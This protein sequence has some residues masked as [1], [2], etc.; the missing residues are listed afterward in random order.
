MV[1]VIKVRYVY[2]TTIKT[3]FGYIPTVCQACAKASGVG[4]GMA[5]WE[6]QPL[7]QRG[8][9]GQQLLS[10]A[11]AGQV[12]EEPSTGLGGAGFFSL[13]VI[14][15]ALKGR[16]YQGPPFALGETEAP[17]WLRSHSQKSSVGGVQVHQRSL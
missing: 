5:W 11:P 17:S 15:T 9:L 12:V 4:R 6:E 8:L 10:C 2:F 13:L 7:A 14:T 3:K 16:R 1:K